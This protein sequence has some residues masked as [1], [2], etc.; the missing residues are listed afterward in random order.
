MKMLGGQVVETKITQGMQLGERR[1]SKP[2][3]GTN[4]KFQNFD[5]RQSQVRGTLYCSNTHIA[6]GELALDLF[7]TVSIHQAT[8]H[9][10]LVY[11]DQQAQIGRQRLI[12]PETLPSA[13]HIDTTSR[14]AF[15]PQ[16]NSRSDQVG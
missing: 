6:Q 11:D 8:G 5:R 2:S 7:K 16:P 3:F 14:K 1:D 9:W 10:H 15:H 13:A 12:S 4:H